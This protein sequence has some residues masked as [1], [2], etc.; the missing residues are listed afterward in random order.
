MKIQRLLFS[1]FVFL[2]DS[3]YSVSHNNI[4]SS[5]PSRSACSDSAA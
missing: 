3:R 4:F 2:A 1:F 5:T